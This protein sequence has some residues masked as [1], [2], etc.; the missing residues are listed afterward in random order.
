MIDLSKYTYMVRHNPNCPSPFEVRTGG[1]AFMVDAREPRN[2]VS[3]GK[4]LDEAMARAAEKIA[5]VERRKQ[6]QRVEERLAG[7]VWA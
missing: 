5:D 6:V 1:G 3:Y 4:T 2:L 7:L